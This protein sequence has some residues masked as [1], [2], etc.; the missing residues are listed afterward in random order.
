MEEL[1]QKIIIEGQSEEKTRE[2]GTL[3]SQ[4]EERKKQEEIL[5]RQKSGVNWLWEVEKNKKKFHQAMIQH[6]QKN[7]IFSILNSEGH[8]VTK[9]EEMEKVL[10]EYHKEMLTEPGINRNEAID[11]ICNEIPKMVNE[12]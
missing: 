3:I 9:H 10:V 7:R 11:K 5:W 2:E 1:Q 6:R 8:R 4:I 12:D